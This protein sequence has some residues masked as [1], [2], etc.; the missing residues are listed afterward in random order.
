MITEIQFATHLSHNTR[1]DVLGDPAVHPPKSPGPSSPF[2][3][4]TYVTGRD[5][6]YTY[7]EAGPAVSGRR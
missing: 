7:Q 2:G 4:A 6:R 1:H 5:S 3:Q